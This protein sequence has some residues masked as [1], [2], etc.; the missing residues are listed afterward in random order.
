MR[1][2]V[3]DK[4]ELAVPQRTEFRAPIVE[5]MREISRER[6]SS[7]IGRSRHYAGVMDLRPY[8][9]DALLHA[10]C[11]HTEPRDHKLELLDT[12]KKTLSQL[13]DQ[14]EVVFNVDPTVLRVMR[15]DLCADVVGVPVSWFQ[16]RAQIRFKRF[17]HEIG[18]TKYGQMGSRKIET[19]IMGKRP[20]VFRIYDKTAECLVD[21]RKRSRKIS[22]DADPLDFTKEY[23]FSSDTILTRVE[24]QIGG[25]KIPSQL[26]TFGKLADNA[27]D[28]N[29]FSP[30]HIIAGQ[31][32]EIPSLA[33][34][35]LSEWLVGTRV[36]QLADEWGM[37]QLRAEINRKSKG[38]A[39]RFLDRYRNFLPSAGENE[40]TSDSIYELYRGSVRAQLGA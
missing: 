16:P 34:C 39:A 2:T 36:R 31:G 17:A 35:T 27:A 33:D 6:G 9:S 30:M 24:R 29:P 25:G 10:Y 5:A 38:N 40:L 37:Q 20:N 19:L 26:S 3:I 15:L 23:G 13:I 1:L 12:G 18:E 7:R 32:S 11:K 14:I 8:G 21:F 22:P 28:F 4:L